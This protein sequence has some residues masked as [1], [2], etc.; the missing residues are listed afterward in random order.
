MGLGELT[1][2]RQGDATDQPFAD[3]LFD[4]AI[5]IHVAMNIAAKDKLYAEARRVVKPGGVFAVYDILQGEGGEALYPAPWAR[6]S[7]ISYLAS[8]E[9]MTALLLGALQLRQDK[10]L[11]DKSFLSLMGLTFKQ[12]PLLTKSSPRDQGKTDESEE[13]KDGQGQDT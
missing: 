1:T 13:S 9:E 11:S 7:S 8:T 2:F 3:D 5:T 4:A 10:R 12:L 6:D